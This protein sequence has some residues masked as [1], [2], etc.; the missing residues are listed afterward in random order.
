MSMSDRTHQTPA[1]EEARETPRQAASDVERTGET[2]PRRRAVRRSVVSWLGNH[3]R[4]P[5]SMI[6]A[7]AT[8]GAVVT[9]AWVTYAAVGIPQK[10]E[11][12][13]FRGH[14]EQDGV[15]VNAEVF[16]RFTAYHGVDAASASAAGW[17]E[18]QTVLPVEGDFNVLL[19]SATALT[20]ATLRPATGM[21]FIG[22]EI[23]SDAAGTSVIA[24][25]DGKQLL[26]PAPY[27]R[28]AALG[29]GFDI[30]GQ[31]SVGGGAAVTGNTDVD[32][33]FSS[34]GGA[35]VG[36]EAS[37]AT[38]RSTGNTT[39]EGDLHVNG[40]FMVDTGETLLHFGGA[41]V[42]AVVGTVSLGS[43]TNRFCFLTGIHVQHTSWS[44]C[45][46]AQGTDGNGLPI[47]Q[48]QATRASDP[49]GDCIAR[50]LSWNGAPADPVP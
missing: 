4:R 22:V 27:A 11:T 9:T 42:G 21:V 46:I 23:V 18:V 37:A 6:L 10:S 33:S 49:D 30:D 25:L 31:L 16:L 36:G 12:L 15:P 1:S 35:T 39:V 17:S 5:V 20:D 48:L 2:P 43:T 40:T 28:G 14:L 3:L 32:G 19:G 45:R 50:C 47:W 7:G 34:T 26:L 8:L 41:S 13:P 44:G 24:A 38:L 29:Q